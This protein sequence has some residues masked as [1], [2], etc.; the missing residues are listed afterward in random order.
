MFV[1]LSKGIY[2][3]LLLTTVPRTRHLTFPAH[4][5]LSRACDLSAK[6]HRSPKTP[7]TTPPL[8]GL[9]LS[10]AQK[11][12][13]LHVCQSQVPA[14]IL[15]LSQASHDTSDL[16]EA[17]G[18]RGRTA[19]VHTSLLPVL[20]WLSCCVCGFLPAPLSQTPL[21][22]RFT[23]SSLSCFQERLC[24]NSRFVSF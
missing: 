9:T 14:Q 10:S 15:L 20:R 7:C 3:C 12:L 4:T 8:R 19:S 11:T 23:E 2:L 18:P 21:G 22:L 1:E 16:A 17:L 13:L 6:A 24:V 5:T